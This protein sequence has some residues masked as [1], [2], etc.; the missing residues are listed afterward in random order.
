MADV[1]GA[2]AY[3]EM[4]PVLMTFDYDGTIVLD[5]SHYSLSQGSAQVGKVVTLVAGGQVGLGASGGYPL[6]KLIKVE[7]D[8]CTVQIAGSMGLPYL[9]GSIPAVGRGVFIDGAGNAQQATGGA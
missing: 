3:D 2:A 8:K 9:G 7:S 4:Q 1:R 6:G 5:P